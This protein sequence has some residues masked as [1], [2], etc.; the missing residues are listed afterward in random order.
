VD[1]HTGAV[2]RYRRHPARILAVWIAAALLVAFV[3]AGAVSKYYWGYAYAK[4]GLD[5]RV[6]DAT[7][8]ATATSFFREPGEPEPLLCNVAYDAK[9][10][11]ELRVEP[12]DAGEYAFNQRAL[13]HLARRGLLPPASATTM[14]ADR[15]ARVTG[16]LDATGRLET[17][18]IGGHV[19]E[20]TGR[21]GEPLLFVSTTGNGGSGAVSN[22]HYPFYEF[23]FARSPVGEP[24]ELLS[25][26]HFY[27]DIAGMEGVEWP[28]MFLL[29]AGLLLAAVVPIVV[30]FLCLRRLIDRSRGSVRGFAVEIAPVGTQG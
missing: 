7:A 21:G 15:V 6:R 26:N 27:F 11:A 30:V 14:P 3:G 16:A 25:S 4:P 24:R 8:V 2:L 20:L 28:Q 17:Q 9:R 18:S 13:R 12:D 29:L 10:L 1:P 19:L 5:R 22:D 23:V